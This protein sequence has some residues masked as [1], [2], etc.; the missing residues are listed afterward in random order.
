MHWRKIVSVEP[1]CDYCNAHDKY[2]CKSLADTANCETFKSL[3]RKLTKKKVIPMNENIEKLVNLSLVSSRSTL[4]VINAL[5]QRGAF[6]G[7]EAGAIGM[8][9][10]QCTQIAQLCETIKSEQANTDSQSED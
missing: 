5:M 6:K 9:Y 1:K 10:D 3:N 4:G 8:L 7:E 2:R